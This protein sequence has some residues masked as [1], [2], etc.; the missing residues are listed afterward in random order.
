MGVPF[1]IVSIGQEGV[2]FGDEFLVEKT[3]DVYERG[4]IT[5]DVTLTEIVPTSIFVP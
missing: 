3:V 2:L 1:Q 4:K 5:R